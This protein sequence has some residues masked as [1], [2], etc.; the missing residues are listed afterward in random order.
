[1]SYPIDNSIF[2]LKRWGC[3]FLSALVLTLSGGA[4]AG[5]STSIGV[6]YAAESPHF[7]I[8][9]APRAGGAAEKAAEKILRRLEIAR[10]A[11]MALHGENWVAEGVLHVWLPENSRAFRKIVDMDYERGI[12]VSGPRLNWIAIDP[13]AAQPEEIVVHEYLHAVLHRRYPSLPRWIE[14]GVCEYYAP[15]R[16]IQKGA[17]PF[18]ESGAAPGNRL[19]VLRRSGGWDVKRL[20]GNEFPAEAYAW[21]WA[22]LHLA[23]RDRELSAL[24]DN[25]VNVRWVQPR[26]DEEFPVKLRPAAAPP[27]ITIQRLDAA[28]AAELRALATAAFEK[29]PGA[30]PGEAR[31]L[32][33]LRLLDEGQASA[34]RVLLEEALRASP[35]QS[36][37]WLTL[38]SA[39]GELDLRTLQREAIGKAINTSATNTEKSAARAAAAAIQ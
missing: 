29:S 36:S 8:V 32:E 6:S 27:Q 31:F 12:F 34:A 15:L 20:T 4:L 25:H 30:V 7:R 16:Y 2:L 17:K 33:G 26:A 19:Q 21:A 3:R 22:H 38:A 37:W 14:E 11:L 18:L 35:S 13:D 23:L 39:Y 1:M 28:R 5:Q 24:L 10:A 9:T